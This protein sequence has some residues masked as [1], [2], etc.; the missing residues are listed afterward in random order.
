MQPQ[1]SSVQ[2][3]RWDNSRDE[4]S[5]AAVSSTEEASGCERISRKLCSGKL[6]ISMKVLGGV[7][8]FWAVFILGYLTGY[9]VHKCK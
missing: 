9:Y 6:G 8:L 4:V 2:Y 3:S 5:V 1:D 7:T